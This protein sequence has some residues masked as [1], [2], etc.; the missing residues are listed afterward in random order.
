MERQVDVQ[1]RLNEI[2]K[3]HGMMA[4]VKTLEVGFLGFYDWL[5][6]GPF[7]N[8]CL[9][10]A[11]GRPTILEFAASAQDTISSNYSNKA[12]TAPGHMVISSYA[13]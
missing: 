7:K 13:S 1:E 12:S 6:S 4:H 10:T 11:S 8:R 2:V 3:T 9:V 5:A